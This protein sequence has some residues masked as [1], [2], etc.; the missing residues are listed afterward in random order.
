M[1]RVKLMKMFDSQHYSINVDKDFLNDKMGQ[2]MDLAREAWKD[3]IDF[4]QNKNDESYNKFLKSFY[5]L[6][7]DQEVVSEDGRSEVDLRLLSIKV[8]HKRLA[9]KI[10]DKMASERIGFDSMFYKYEE[11]YNKINLSPFPEYEELYWLILFL[12][13]CIIGVCK[14]SYGRY[15]RWRNWQ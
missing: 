13:C 11:A 12:L 6:T 5:E 9:N 10:F 2:I 4:Y 15:F 7:F 1:D 8:N 3:Y 14:E